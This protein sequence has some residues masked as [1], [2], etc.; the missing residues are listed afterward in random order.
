MVH[1]GD[2]DHND[3]KGAQ[4]VGARAVLF[5]AARDKDKSDTTADAICENYAELP[6]IIARLDAS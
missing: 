3:V 5:T 1:I 2:R 4:A 6:A